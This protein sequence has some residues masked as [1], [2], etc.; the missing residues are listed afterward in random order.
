MKVAI[1]GDIHGNNIA[2]ESVLK[3]VE[4]EEAE[5]IICTGDY[6][7]YYYH[8]DKVFDLLEN[9]TQ[10]AVR[11]NH[12][13]IFL[14]ISG[15]NRELAAM[16]KEK[17]GSGMEFALEK[18]HT[19]RIIYLKQLPDQKTITVDG[20]KALLCHGSP[21][22]VN[23]YIYPDSDLSKFDQLADHG[24][25]LVIMGHTH[26]PMVRHAGDLLLVNPGSVGQSRKGPAGAYWML[27]DTALNKVE[28][29]T[30]SYDMET[31]IEEVS[32]V[33][34]QIKYLSEVLKRK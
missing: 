21:W 28:Q 16:Y 15:G 27:W 23:E 25:D 5:M 3:N 34:R 2:L 30:V 7:G 26:Y 22:D 9:W 20:R 12:D 24:Y 32:G 8:P 14:D 19:E 6:L 18:L 33:D 10:E 11:G 31:V 17:F 29:K 13:L 4:R 1:I